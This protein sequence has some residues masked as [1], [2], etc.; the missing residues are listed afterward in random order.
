MSLNQ[1]EQMIFDYVQRHPEERHY[2][3][4][5]VRKTSLSSTDD[6]VA[7]ATLEPELW[8]Y[9]QERSSVASPF[10]EHVQRQG[11]QRVSMKN[12]AEHLLRLWVGPRPKKATARGPAE[13]LI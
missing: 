7:A 8:R 6:H 9:F 5:K 4:E 13:E 1:S 2:W 12:L 3:L 10:R 11:L